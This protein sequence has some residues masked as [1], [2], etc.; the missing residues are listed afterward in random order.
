MSSIRV[1]GTVSCSAQLLMATR[2]FSVA[3]R[4]P[5]LQEIPNTSPSSLK[6]YAVYLA[7]CAFVAG[8][9]KWQPSE[10]IPTI[11]PVS[12]SALPSKILMR[13]G[14]ESSHT[15]FFVSLLSVLPYS[16]HLKSTP[17]CSTYPRMLRGSLNTPVLPSTM[18]ESRIW[19][20]SL[21]LTSSS[22]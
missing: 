13:T 4:R 7:P 2:K 10:T 14:G 21:L 11:D 18:N 20:L 17:P 15:L 9:P 5:F 22:L 3:H 6:R 19:S 1:H 12:R 16:K 8:V